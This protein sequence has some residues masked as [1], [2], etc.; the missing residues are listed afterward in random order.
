MPTPNKTIPD[1][2]CLQYLNSISTDTE[3]HNQLQQLTS[4]PLFLNGTI[5]QKMFEFDGEMLPYDGEITSYDPINK[6]YHIIYDD[7]DYEDLDATEVKRHRRQY[8]KS[9]RA[10]GVKSFSDSEQEEH[11]NQDSNFWKRNLQS[12]ILAST[13][14]REARNKRRRKG[15]EQKDNE[16]RKGGLQIGS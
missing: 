12:Q 7:G 3:T 11:D 10:P 13:N 8:L 9:S 4:T 1:R 2:T 14:F 15:N 5:I 16:W 6:W